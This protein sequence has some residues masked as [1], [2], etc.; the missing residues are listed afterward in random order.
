MPASLYRSEFA[1]PVISR[2]LLWLARHDWLV[3][4]ALLPVFI[5]ADRLPGS[6]LGAAVLLIALTWMARS[7]ARLPLWVR[8][9]LDL[10]IICLLVTVPL[11]LYASV[12]LAVSLPRLLN[13]LFGL[14]LYGAVVRA[15]TS[16]ERYP[17]PLGVWLATGVVIA[18]LA[19][20]S[21]DWVSLKFP[22]LSVLTT[23]L[24]RLLTGLG[25]RAGQGLNS[26]VVGGTLALFTP[27][28]VGLWLFGASAAR[29]STASASEASKTAHS[30]WQWL[31]F[32]AQPG[33]SLWLIALIIVGGLTVLT[34]SRSA[35]LGVALATALLLAV[36]SRLMRWLAIAGVAAGLV[37]IL[38]IGPSTLGDALFGN[39][40]T[41]A[42]S[43]NLNFAEREEVWSRAI[44][45]IQDFPFTGVGLGQFETVA[46]LL[47]PFFLAGPDAQVPHA[48]DIYLEMAVDFGIGG[49]VAFAAML[50]A[51]AISVFR[52]YRRLA[53]P[54]RLMLLCFA[55][56][57][58]AYQVFGLS[59]AIPLGTRVSFEWWLLLGLING[60]ALI[61]NP[62]PV[63]SPRRQL[64]PILEQFALWLLGS[65]VAISFVG[66]NGLLGIG[67]AL[68]VGILLG[69]YVSALPPA[70]PVAPGGKAKQAKPST[71]S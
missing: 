24:P 58:L 43:G 47:Y 5:Y 2:P 8:T 7:L 10:P 39:G 44:Y 3:L 65:L 54:A 18:L 64:G 22:V 12:D 4:T 67:L 52:S 14:A 34:Q 11:A 6:V 57:L 13:L 25:S 50:V 33:R 63:W 38:I 29:T 71:S 30:R 45:A 21:V 59:D 28:L 9:P 56:G 68:C 51:T 70:L 15:I 31:D 35:L 53:E 41:T 1:L 16:G 37:A 26:N 46:R 60:V 49:L 66:E 23:R 42:S 17:W 20:V 27:A 36:R 62:L 48:H 55:A 61:G 40:S 19:L 69:F 32:A